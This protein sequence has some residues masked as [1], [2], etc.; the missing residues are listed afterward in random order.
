MH[1][2]QFKTKKF[3]LLILVVKFVELFPDVFFCS[4]IISFLLTF[5]SLFFLMCVSRNIKAHIL[6]KV[7]R[8]RKKLDVENETFFLL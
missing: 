5:H 4:S 6:Y 3:T 1:F 2:K 8:E 7:K